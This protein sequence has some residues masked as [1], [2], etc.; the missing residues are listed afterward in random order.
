MANQ[1]PLIG[2]PALTKAALAYVVQDVS[3]ALSNLCIAID[4]TPTGETRNKLTE[5]NIHIMEAERI[6]KGITDEY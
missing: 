6:I 3:G 4:A 2:N 1:A 5:A